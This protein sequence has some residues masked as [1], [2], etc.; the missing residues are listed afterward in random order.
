VL[1]LPACGHLHWPRMPWSH[2]GGGGAREKK[3]EPIDLNRAPLSKIE[4]LP[5]VTPSMAKKIVE[6][7]PYDDPIDLVRRGLL[8]RQDFMRVDD[9][10]TVEPPAK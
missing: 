4:T 6:G 9:L 5:G 1:A 7:R 10:V 2:D 8:T 3:P